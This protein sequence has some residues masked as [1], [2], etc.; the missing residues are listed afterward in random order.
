[1]ALH[2]AADRDRDGPRER[3]V[4]R[5]PDPEAVPRGEQERETG[6]G[7]PRAG[8][9][10]VQTG[11]DPRAHPQP[12]RASAAR[13]AAASISPGSAAITNWGKTSYSYVSTWP[14]TAPRRRFASA[15]GLAT[16]PSTAASA[17]RAS[18]SASCSA[19]A[20]ARGS[21][22]ITASASR[23]RGYRELA[24]A[25]AI[26]RSVTCSS[27]RNENGSIA[28]HPQKS[29]IHIL[30]RAGRSAP[31][32]EGSARSRRRDGRPPDAHP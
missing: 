23:S 14:T 25:S 24:Y 32:A 31:A 28:G 10:V 16:K 7:E 18:A 11:H 13:R 9:H 30:R 20:S 1:E 27:V 12:S 2:R 5:E 8:G 22:Q 29:H 6:R 4:Q 19:S 17:S 26:V 15:S 21:A 3:Q